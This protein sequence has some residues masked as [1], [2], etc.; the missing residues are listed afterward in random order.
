MLPTHFVGECV[1]SA[2]VVESILKVGADVE[3]GRNVGPSDS[4]G[5]GRGKTLGGVIVSLSSAM[6]GLVLVSL[7]SVVVGEG[8]IKVVV[9]VEPPNGDAVV[10]ALVLEEGGPVIFPIPPRKT[11]VVPPDPLLS[12]L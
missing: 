9:V 8:L 5:E 11:L 1:G 7:A 3:G 10:G 4:S 2:L 6:V 12:S